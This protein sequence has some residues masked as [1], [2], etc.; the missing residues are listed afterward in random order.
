MIEISIDGYCISR[1]CDGYFALSIGDKQY[2]TFVTDFDG[3]YDIN[4][5]DGGRRSGIFVYPQCGSNSIVSGDPSGILPS[6]VSDFTRPNLRDSLSEGEDD[7]FDRLTTQQNGE[8]FPIIFT[9]I[10]NDIT[11]T[12]TFRF[13]SPKFSGTNE[14]SCTYNGAVDTCQDFKLYITPDGGKE[15]LK[16]KDFTVR[17]YDLL[18]YSIIL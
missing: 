6:T 13:R 14:L 17:G 1:E 12:F 16:I 5:G 3:Y 10:N 11:N 4:L 15:T 8:K 18:L 2:L 9:L 7:N